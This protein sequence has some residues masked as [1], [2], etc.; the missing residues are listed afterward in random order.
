MCN[1]SMS[2]RFYIRH[3]M[4]ANREESSIYKRPCEASGR[5]FSKTFGEKMVHEKGRV[6]NCVSYGVVV[7]VEVIQA[8]FGS[9]SER[10]LTSS[11]EYSSFSC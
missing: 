6:R 2:T 5:R 1:H 3:E 7:G 11:C 10:S 9:L 8:P 4:Y